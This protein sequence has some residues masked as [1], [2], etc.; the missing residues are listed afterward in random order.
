MTVSANGVQWLW[1]A[2]VSGWTKRI[3]LT[4]LRWLLQ[5][6]IFLFAF[7]LALLETTSETTVR[8]A[9][10]ASHDLGQS[11]TP[12]SFSN[13]AVL[14]YSTLVCA[15][16]LK[17]SSFLLNLCFE[18]YFLSSVALCTFRHL[19]YFTVSCLHLAGSKNQTLFILMPHHKSL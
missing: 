9:A 15:G 6:W 8:L 16:N 3:F 12:S 17:E 11:V 7:L 1:G 18:V 19:L 2:F 4:F 14:W 10:V 5:R 13:E